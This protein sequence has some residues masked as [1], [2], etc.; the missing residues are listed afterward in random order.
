MHAPTWKNTFDTGNLLTVIAF[1]VAGGA[2]WGT[3]STRIDNMQQNSAE[4]RAAFESRVT[5]LETKIAPIDAMIYRLGKQES[6]TTAVNLK[7]DA[8]A[9]AF[10]VSVDGLRKD[11]YSVGSKVDVL[12]E[13][14][15]EQ[16]RRR[17]GDRDQ[18]GMLTKPN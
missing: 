4:R 12:S 5:A 6:D 14:M 2:A 11:I 3:L 10:S 1:L 8:A 13:R 17:N 15:Q 7:M 9:T 16:E 18:Q